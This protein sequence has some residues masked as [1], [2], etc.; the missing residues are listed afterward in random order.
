LALLIF[1]GPSR[2]ASVPP[3]PIPRASITPKDLGVIVAQGDPVSQQIGQYYAQVRGIPAANIIQV[4]I[5]TGSDTISDTDFAAIKAQVDSELPSN[6]QATLL[7]WTAPSRVVGAGGAMSITSA[8]A[9]GYD[10][11]WTETTPC[12]PTAP[13]PYYNSDST[14]PWTDFHMR[15]SMMLGESTFAA[16]QALIDRGVSSDMTYPSGN[17]YLIRTTDVARS[18]RWYDFAPLP[19][20]WSHPNGLSL[21]YIDNSNGT[22]LDYIANTSNVLFYFTGLASVP[23]IATNT[24]LPGAIA[25]HLTSYGGVLPTGAGQMPATAWL[26][27]GATGSYGT[28]QEPCNYTPKFPQA[29]VVIDQYYRGATLIEAYWKSVQ[30]PGEGLFLGEPLARPFEDHASS[31]VEA[32]QY[33]ISTRSLH[34]NSRYEIQYR[35]NPSSVWSIDSDLAMPTTSRSPGARRWP[36]RAT[37]RASPVPARRRPPCT[38]SAA[39]GFKADGR[40]PSIWSSPSTRAPA[41]AA[42]TTTTCPWGP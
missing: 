3:I 7:T 14:T 13:S 2:G 8:M 15:P 41:A 24:Y 4:P 33:V 27:A 22:G 21:N 42:P 17:G 19:A 29:S 28:V 6:V 20:L 36:P 37:R 39:R 18:V 32:G 35:S 5:N 40:K 23:E 11:K 10:P 30:W 12:S 9:F 31:K 1:A 38:R 34:G 16:A 25:D 26:D